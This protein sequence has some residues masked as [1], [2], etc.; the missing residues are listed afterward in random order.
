MTTIAKQN[1]KSSFDNSVEYF[2][3]QETEVLQCLEMGI[4]DAWSIAA[5]KNLLITSVR[6]ALTDLCQADYIYESGTKFNEETQRTVTTYGI[7]NKP[8]TLF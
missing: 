2:G 4:N 5:H 6:R 1:R 8:N 7:T 3:K